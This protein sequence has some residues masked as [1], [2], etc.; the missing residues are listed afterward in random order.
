VS[1]NS[2]PPPY[3]PAELLTTTQS[4]AAFDQ[5]PP[6]LRQALDYAPFEI[7][8]P[9]VLDAVK[10]GIPEAEILRSIDRCIA[11]ALVLAAG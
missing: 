11:Q 10:I 8:A 6:R 9:S 1:H 7:S 5:L 4:M 2:N 3:L